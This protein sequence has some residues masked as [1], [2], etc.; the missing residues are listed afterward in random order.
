MLNLL[1]SAC[2]GVLAA[3][4]ADELRAEIVR[5]TGNYGFKNVCALVAIER[6][7]EPTKNVYIENAPATLREAMTPELVLRDPVTM[8]S[9]TTSG[10]IFWNQKI[11]QSP[12]CKDIFDILAGHGL[13]SGVLFPSHLVG[14]RHFVF[15]VDTESERAIP[16]KH[17][18]QVVADL[19]LFAVHAFD[20]VAR[21]YFQGF[22]YEENPG[23]DLKEAQALQWLFDLNTIDEIA[24]KLN[25][26]VAETE[27][28]LSSATQKLAC[29]NAHHAA[30][31]AV[32]IG[33]I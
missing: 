10:P 31:A 28:R 17:F 18:E 23:V 24:N 4:N 5:F 26:S 9:M 14:G 7:G 22:P 15:A 1:D 11:Y 33:I 32:R 30:L 8:G 29:V 20:T 12:K 19:Q 16:Q 25:I 6:A 3:Q 27:S 21:L 13:R 2:E